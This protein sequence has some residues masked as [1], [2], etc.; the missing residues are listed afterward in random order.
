MQQMIAEGL[1]DEPFLWLDAYNGM[2]KRRIAG[3]ILFGYDFRNHW[4]VTTNH[5]NDRKQQKMIAQ[6]NIQTRECRCFD[7]RKLSPRECLTLM[8]V[9]KEYIDRMM[10]KAVRTYKAIDGCE[11]ELALLGLD[12]AATARE[13]REAAEEL[14]NNKNE[15]DEDESNRV[16]EEQRPTGGGAEIQN[17]GSSELP[18]ILLR[19]QRLQGQTDGDGEHDAVLADR[20]LSGPLT[21]E[22]TDGPHGDETHDYIVTHST[23]KTAG[24]FVQEVLRERADEWGEFIF[25]DNYSGFKYRHGVLLNPLPDEKANQKIVSIKANGGWSAMDY[26]IYTSDYY[27]EQKE[28]V[29]KENEKNLTIEQAR[30]RL[31]AAPR[32]ERTALVQRISNSSL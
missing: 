29:E 31:L 24:E 5:T 10:Q 22:I 2:T 14:L 6:I 11:V 20:I 8:G 25:G 19:R 17:Q 18:D 28:E 12:D 27:K 30:D 3:T 7:I 4:Y 32:V 21:L 26:N 1:I 13:I 16:G 15:D 9:P 23:A